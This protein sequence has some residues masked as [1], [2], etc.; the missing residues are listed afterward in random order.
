MTLSITSSFQEGAL[1]G[2]DK[3]NLEWYC[4]SCAEIMTQ[5]PALWKTCKSKTP[6][7]MDPFV[8]YSICKTTTSS[9]QGVLKRT[10]MYKERLLVCIVER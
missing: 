9:G 6:K 4:D 2:L 10:L 8:S 5:P 7:T 1:L 3:M